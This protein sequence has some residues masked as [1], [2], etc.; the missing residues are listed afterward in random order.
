MGSADRQRPGGLLEPVVESL[1]D[2]IVLIENDRILK[3]NSSYDRITGLKG[4]ALLGKRVDELDGEAHVCLHII[5]EVYRLVRQLGKSVTSMAKLSRGNEIY[6]TGTPVPQEGPARHT[7]VLFRDITELQL[8]KE[9]VSRLTALYLSTPEEVRISQITGQE[10][11]TESREMRGILDLVTR[12][13]QVDSVVLFEGESGTGK[14]VL[15]RLLH[16]LSPRRKG[17]FIAVNCGAIPETLFESELFGYARGA[18]TGALSTGKP[19]LFELAQGGV[20][21]LDEIAEMPLNCQV[22]LL[23]AIEQPEITRLGDVKSVSLNV[24]IVAATNRNLPRAVKEG[25]FREDLFYRLYVVPIKI[26]PL[27]ERREDIFPLVWHFLGA[28]NK[29]FNQSK[30]FSRETIQILESHAWPGNVRELQNAVERMVLVS[31]SETIEPRHLPPGICPQDPDEDN[32]VQVRGVMPWNQARELLE[33]RLLS[34]ALRLHGTTREVARMLAVD[35][36][37]VVRKMRKYGLRPM[38]NGARRDGQ[39]GFSHEE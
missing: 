31:D 12:L 13:A 10:I 1:H 25:T 19:G 5:Q 15:A 27:R 36:S 11:V 18:F 35:H 30:K 7:A 8:L 2:A 26:P 34:Q 24:R 14:E 3:V 23:K 39:G 16:R 28:C 6:V 17:P 4:E 21:F 38:R 22:K 20:I 9:E 33:K 29:R 37:T 32:L